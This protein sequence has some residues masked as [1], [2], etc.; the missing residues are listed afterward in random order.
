MSDNASGGTNELLRR[1]VSDLV[2]ADGGGDSQPKSGSDS[3]APSGAASNLTATSYA[4]LV[5]IGRD[6]YERALVRREQEHITDPRGNSIGWLLDTR[7]PMLDG[8]TFREVGA[9]LADRLTSR[10]IQQIAGFGFGSYALVCS[11][12][13]APSA[14]DFAGGFIREQRKAYGRRRLVEGPIDRSRPVVLLDDILNSGRS[15]LTGAALLRSD[16]YEVEGVMTLFNFTWSG[17]RPR[18]ER[19]GLWVDTLLDLNLREQPSP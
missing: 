18:L 14:I 4:S 15:A 8:E 10:G 16:G 19:E 11:V 5:E 2:A 9:V 17:G 6:L 12:L 13:S 3:G 7:T 1:K